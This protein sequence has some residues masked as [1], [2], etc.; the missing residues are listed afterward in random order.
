MECR[1]CNNSHS[2]K[3]YSVK[4]MMLG[5]RDEFTYIECS[6]CGCLQI[7]TIPEN[8]DKYYP[9]D[10]YSYSKDFIYAKSKTN[11]IIKKIR[12]HYIVFK[13]GLTGKI[14]NRYLPN[15]DPHHTILSEIPLTKES[16]IL[17][18]GCGGGYLLLSLQKLGFKHLL[19]TDPYID[20][21][22]DYENGVRVLK[23]P[24]SSINDKKDLIMFH[25]SFEHM[26]DPQETLV[27]VSRLLKDDGYCIIRV[28]TVSSYAWKHYKENWVQLDAPRHFFLHSR[29]SMNYMANKASL[30]I[31]KV[32]FD[33]T[34]FQ[35]L[36]SEKY[37][38]DLP[39]HDGT[40]YEDIFT[41]SQI[42]D[43]ELKARELNK[44]Q[45]GDACAFILKKN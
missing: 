43:F 32:V 41:E 19:G 12:D 26:P 39:L 7:A 22:I 30:S 44:K 15:K 45:Q 36:G 42:K 33:S 10:Y 1:I 11:E 24:L 5:L 25:H 8:M 38:R 35:F 18:V 17:D 16:E 27:T 14:I 37:K 4:E 20:K 21:D 23:A 2:N 40:P 29:E 6:K 31:E 3:E 9:S 28:P 34:A 13:R